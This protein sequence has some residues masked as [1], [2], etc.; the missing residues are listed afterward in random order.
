M[1]VVHTVVNLNVYW[2]IMYTFQSVYLSRNRKMVN[3]TEIEIDQRDY[4]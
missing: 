3:E 2:D 1:Y 4:G